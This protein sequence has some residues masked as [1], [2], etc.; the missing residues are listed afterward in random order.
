MSRDEPDPKRSAVK[1][2]SPG[3]Q[4]GRP[5]GEREHRF[6]RLKEVESGWTLGRGHLRRQ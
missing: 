5:G 2:Y 1:G 3:E 4:V 6:E